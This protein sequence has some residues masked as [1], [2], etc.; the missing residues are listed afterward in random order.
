MN[1]TKVAE[2]FDLTSAT[3]R[4]YEQVGLIPPVRR[5]ENGVRDYT[6][7]DI[8]WVEFIKCMRSAGLT[9]EALIEYTS[10]FMKGDHTLEDRKK[11]L[12]DERTKLAAKQR[13]IEET[14]RRLDLKIDDYDGILSACEAELDTDRIAESKET[15][16]GN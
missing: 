7:E 11:I 12:I 5:K 8:K 10:L 1:I 6:E 3:L 15:R 9:I 4:Y 13:E 14:I 16:T 2:Q